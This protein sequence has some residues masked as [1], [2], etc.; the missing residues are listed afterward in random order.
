[1]LTGRAPATRVRDFTKCAISSS[2]T[3][4]NSRFI[5]FLPDCRLPADDFG[6]CTVAAGRRI[7]CGVPHSSLLCCY[8][9]R[10]A[11]TCL[12]DFACRRGIIRSRLVTGCCGPDRAMSGSK[13]GCPRTLSRQGLPWTLADWDYSWRHWSLSPPWPC[14]LR[15]S[16]PHDNATNHLL[17]RL[18]LLTC[19]L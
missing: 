16:V 1:M 15:Q 6:N 19:L 13:V 11:C 8:S 4:V 14:C 2:V 7:S 18:F 10:P 9:R 17:R 5:L 3:C 12:G